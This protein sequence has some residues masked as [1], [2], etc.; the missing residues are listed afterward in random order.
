MLRRSNML[1]LLSTLIAM[2][3][4][5]TLYLIRIAAISHSGW[6]RVEKNKIYDLELEL[7][8][9]INNNCHLVLATRLPDDG[10]KG[11]WMGKMD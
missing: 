11:L 6:H 8:S 5:G 10:Y 2:L 9:D 4:P 1:W 7:P 3:K